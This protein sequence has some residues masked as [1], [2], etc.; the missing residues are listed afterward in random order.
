[1][2]TEIKPGATFDT[3]TADELQS[4]LDELAS[5]YLRP[6]QHVRF[7]QGGALSGAG[8]GTIEIYRPAAGYLFSLSRLVI[9]PGPPYTFGNPFTGAAGYLQI[10]VGGQPYDGAGFAS[11]GTAANISLPAV[12]TENA[13]VAIWARDGELMQL[14]IVAG[15]ANATVL[16][17]GTGMLTPMP[18]D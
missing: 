11:T 5:G 15:P 3:L 10:L 7:E 8:A 2:R 12:L 1:M 14:Q 6:P 9:D 18:V 16:I 13:A 4:V 17:R